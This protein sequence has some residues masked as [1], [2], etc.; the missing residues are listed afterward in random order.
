MR[1]Q[2][3]DVRSYNGTTEEKST[4]GERSTFFV[5][6]E[7]PAGLDAPPV[8]YPNAPTFEVNERITKFLER[9]L[10]MPFDGKR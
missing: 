1:Y 10:T 8:I 9:R 5:T 4:D 7:F 6:L 3:P 2:K